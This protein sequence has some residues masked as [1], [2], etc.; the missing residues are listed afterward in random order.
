[1]EYLDQMDESL[2]GSKLDMPA[3]PISKLAMLTTPGQGG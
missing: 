2:D 1:M 3:R